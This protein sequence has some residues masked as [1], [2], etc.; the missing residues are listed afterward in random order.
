LCPLS[1]LALYRLSPGSYRSPRDK[2]RQS[3]TDAT[4]PDVGAGQTAPMTQDTVRTRRNFPAETWAVVR[5]AYLG[6]ETAESI[7]RRLNMSVNTIRKRASRCGWTHAAHA[8]AIQRACEEGPTAPIDLARARDAAVTHAAALLAEGRALEASAMLRA[9]E[10]LGR[11]GGSDA[12]GGA[13]DTPESEADA[14]VDETLRQISGH[15]DRIAAERAGQLALDLLTDEGPPRAVY[16]AFA[17]RWRARVLGPAVALADYAR[18]LQGGWAS[19]YWDAEGRLIPQDPVPPAPDPGMVRQHLRLC[20][21][22]AGGDEG[23]GDGDWVWPPRDW[24]GEGED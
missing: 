1:P 3:G 18:G 19:R 6:G 20:R 17:W 5:D 24:W 9:A 11:A 4:V 21:G 14:V 8:R 22:A 23:D 12:G 10:A 2:P 7:G 16:G 15:I 13:A